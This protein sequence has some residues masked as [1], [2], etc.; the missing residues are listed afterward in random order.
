MSSV[1]KLRGGRVDGGSG[2][3]EEKKTN[4]RK[5]RKSLKQSS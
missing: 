4:H 5:G 3:A 2:K 1:H